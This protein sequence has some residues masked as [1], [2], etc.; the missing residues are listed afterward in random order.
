MSSA[1]SFTA[2][3]HLFEDN[4]WFYHFLVPNPIAEQ[5]LAS[6]TGRRVLCT[7][8]HSQSYHCSLMPDGLGG[9]F[10]NVNQ[11]LREKLQLHDGSPLY[12]LLLPDTTEF[13]MPMPE[14]LE[15][16]LN[17]DEA[18]KS[19]FNALTPGKQRNL[20]YIV[21]TVKSNAIKMRRAL[22][23]A[24]HIKAYP[25]LDFKALNVALKAANQD[26]K[27]SGR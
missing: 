17:Q 7:L 19:L 21:S 1:H 6:P 15:E 2:T 9:W 27:S 5:L 4:L 18:A 23:I 26:A 12:V 22:V 13:G 16:C 20:I 3:L 25:K 24:A 14:E 8:Q 11:Q 10:I